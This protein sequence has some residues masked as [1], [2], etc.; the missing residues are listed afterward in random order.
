MN[1]IY[2]TGEPRPLE[3]TLSWALPWTPS[4]DVSWELSLTTHT[5][6]MKGVEVHPLN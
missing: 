3:W 6:L 1:L 2:R 4:W 5:T